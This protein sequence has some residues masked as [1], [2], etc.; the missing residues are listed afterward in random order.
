MLAMI[1]DKLELCC[2]AMPTSHRSEKRLAAIKI[3]IGF[4]RDC[5]SVSVKQAQKIVVENAVATVA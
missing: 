5:L 4:G 2:R 1:V 3:L